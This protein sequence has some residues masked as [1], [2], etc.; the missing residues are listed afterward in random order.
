MEP[1]KKPIKSEDKQ[2]IE[3]IF[4]NALGNVVILKNTPTN[5]QMKANTL[6]YYNNELFVKL[7][8]GETKKI[9]LTDVS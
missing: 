5:A 4:N 7:A 2:V 8:N 6:G 3:H 9:S 1:I